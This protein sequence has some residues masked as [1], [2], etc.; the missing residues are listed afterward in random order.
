MPL[1]ARPAAGHRPDPGPG[2]P[3]RRRSP[4]AARS[5]HDPGGRPRRQPRRTEPPP[6]LDA[7]AACIRKR[8]TRRPS[9]PDSGAERPRAESESGHAPRRTTIPDAGARRRTVTAHRRGGVR[10]AGARPGSTHPVRQRRPCGT[11]G[12]RRGEIPLF[13]WIYPAAARLRTR[14]G[15]PS[16]TAQRTEYPRTPPAHGRAATAAGQCHATAQRSSLGSQADGPQRA[17]R[18]LR[19]TGPGRLRRRP[20]P[21]RPWA[22]RCRPR[23]RPRRRP[24]ARRR[25]VPGA[26]PAPVAR[27]TDRAPVMSDPREAEVRPPR[28]PQPRDRPRCRTLV[29]AAARRPARRPRRDPE[30]GP[31]S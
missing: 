9:A 1:R 27:E 18:A 24:P 11:G 23:R 17:R 5:G 3:V 4:P 31:S 21:G 19:R 12:R 10:P 7:G 29:I 28:F 13:G 26:R 14:T 8:R 6:R 20:R 30:A 15:I 22:G 2:A 25:H 16:G